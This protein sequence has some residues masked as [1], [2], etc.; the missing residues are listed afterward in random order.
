MSEL[1]R[2]G[3]F[4]SSEIW[5]LTK[6]DRSGKGFG[7]AALTYIE[8]K[9]ME[10]KLG[11]G[12]SS[13]SNAKPTNWGTVIEG[14]AFQKIGLEFSMVSKD[15]LQHPTIK[16]WVG[17]PDLVSDT[18][19]G[20]EKCPFTMKSFCKLADIIET[21]DYKQLKENNGAYDDGFKYYWQ[22]V[23]NS[24]LTG[25]TTA[26]LVVYCPYLSELDKIR[27]YASMEYEGDLNKAAF[28]N[29]SQDNELPYLP[30]GGHYKDVNILE[31]EVPQEDKDYLTDLVLEASKLLNN[32]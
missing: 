19:V 30:D 5:R 15:R 24:I 31:F 21:G 2:Y 14:Y 22:L 32:N 29:F 7:A 16:N 20:D 17:V 8:E 23:S 6:T 13:E 27:D 28:I 11:R 4:S 9:R 12:L 18:K 3:N 10:I 26:V 25:K 1:H